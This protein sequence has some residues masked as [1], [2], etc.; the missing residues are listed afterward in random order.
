[1]NYATQI[2]TYLSTASP[3]S[4]V[5][6]APSAP[7]VDR[8]EKGLH[9]VLN[10]ILTPQDIREALTTFRSHTPSLGS[11][12]PGRSGVFSFGLQ[13]LGRFKIGYFTQRGTNVVTVRRVAMEI[14]SLDTLVPSQET[15][16]KLDALIAGRG[17]GIILVTG[18]SNNHNSAFCY[19]LLQRVCRTQDR[20]IYTIE[21]TLSY[22]LRHDRSLV[23]Q[24]EM[25]TDIASFD[26][27]FQHAINLQPDI[28]Y[29]RDSRPPPRPGELP[30]LM[31]VSSANILTM[32]NIAAVDEVMLLRDIASELKELDENFHRLLRGIIRITPE[33]ESR[34]QVT[35]IPPA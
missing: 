20:V 9:V 28:L 18:P 33:P 2:L 7:P 26:E 3:F 14:P 31:E 10:V 23:L 27:G 16:A 15:T 13:N 35:V 30:R 11:A 4:E 12:A 25:E 17:A 1:M 34:M 32:L 22:L 6:L 8:S 21:R 5:I 29:V 24:S 19:S